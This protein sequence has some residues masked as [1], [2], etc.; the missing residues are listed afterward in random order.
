[1]KVC[2]VL[3]VHDF[4]NLLAHNLLQSNKLLKKTPHSPFISP[5]SCIQGHLSR[6][7]AWENYQRQEKVGGETCDGTHRFNRQ[8]VSSVGKTLDYCVGGGGFKPRSDQHS[9]LKITEEK[10]LPL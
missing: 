6:K 9:G 4:D 8:P 1:M 2:L 5:A 7:D 10:V 3:E